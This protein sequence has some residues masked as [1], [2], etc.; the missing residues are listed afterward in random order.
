MDNKIQKIDA[1]S[2]LVDLSDLWLNNNSIQDINAISS[3]V[4]LK[5]LDIGGCNISDIG[6]LA[7][8]TKLVRLYCA[9]NRIRDISPLSNITIMQYLDLT[10]NDINDI[11]ALSSLIN[12]KGLGIYWNHISNINSLSPLT[13]L[14]SLDI[15]SNNISDLSVLLNL[16]SLQ[17]VWI[18]GTPIDHHPGS[19]ALSVINQLIRRGVIINAGSKEYVTFTFDSMGG[20]T[21]PDISAFYYAYISEPTPPSKSGMLFGGWYIEPTGTYPW[22]YKTDY[23]ERDTILYAKWTVDASYKPSAAL[24]RITL[25]SGRLTRAFDQNVMNYT[26]QL[27]DADEGITITPVKA[28]DQAGMTID[29]ASIAQ[30]YIKVANGKSIKTTIK[31]VCGRLSKTYTFTIKRAKS[32]NNNL[33][34]ITSSAGT[35][36]APFDPAMLNYTVNL[37]DN[38]AKTTIKAVAQSPLSKVSPSVK[39]YSLKNGESK[40]ISIKVKAQSGAARVY[41]ITI[42]RARSSKADLMWIKTNTSRYPLMPAFNAGN[43]N[44]TVTLSANVSSI[45]IS[46][47]QTDKLSKVTIDN[48]KKNSKKFTLSNGQSITV[49]VV[50]TAQ[51]G[52]T[53]EYIITINRQ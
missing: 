28:Y 49:H 24:S 30:K 16:N 20:S 5:D 25:S 52:N 21:C 40:K 44:Y 38:T 51:A 35:I 43:A 6:P 10:D 39:T 23:A 4:N 22:H 42:I 19:A 1:F 31:L 47:K 33:Q 41:T 15:G 13:N 34:S 17:N 27:G 2:S 14:L 36:S 32:A 46:A 50:V 18:A 8:C 3:L 37:D 9:K 29:K 48:V 11:T 53:K 26:I 7:S 12:L 45:V